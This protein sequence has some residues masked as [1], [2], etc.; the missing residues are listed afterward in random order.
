LVQIT[1]SL[2]H[3]CSIGQPHTWRKDC[4]FQTETLPQ[5]PAT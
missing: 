2:R 5:Q 3:V 4:G 1:R